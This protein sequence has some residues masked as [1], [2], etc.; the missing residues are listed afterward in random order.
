MSRLQLT[1]GGGKIGLVVIASV[2]LCASAQAATFYYEGSYVHNAAGPPSTGVAQVTIEDTGPGA[3]TLTAELGGTIFG[4]MTPP[5]VSITMPGNLAGILWTYST[6]GH[7]VFG[8]A[9]ITID[10]ATGAITGTAANI[11]LLGTTFSMNGVGTATDP[12][13][14][15]TGDNF[16]INFDVFDLGALIGSGDL[17]ADFQAGV[18]TTGYPALALLALLLLAGGFLVLRRSARPAA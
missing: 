16:T 17:D 14:P 10:D 15:M 3:R 18:P 6:T 4:V 7:P 12:V 5:L 11:M 9:T 2:L 13:T 8:D 1:L